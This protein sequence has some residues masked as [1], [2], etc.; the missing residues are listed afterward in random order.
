MR[1]RQ[2]N[3]LVV[4]LARVAEQE[5]L[6]PGHVLGYGVDGRV[7]PALI[8]AQ[9]LDLI[10]APPAGGPPRH[11]GRE[12]L[13]QPGIVAAAV[14]PGLDTRHQGHGNAPQLAAC[15]FAD[16]CEAASGSSTFRY[17]KPFSTRSTSCHA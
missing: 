15:G 2:R 17:P 16:S 9:L 1:V 10:V 3:L 4:G 13:R 11:R 8:V 12:H 6:L 7:N 5:R 14:E